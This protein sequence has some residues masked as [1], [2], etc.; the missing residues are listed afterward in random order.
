MYCLQ[1]RSAEKIFVST[2]PITRLIRPAAERTSA[3]ETSGVFICCSKESA[4]KL[5]QV[6]GSLSRFQD[7]ITVAE[8]VPN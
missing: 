4:F 2:N 6:G 1:M 8:F 3:S 5:L 7:G